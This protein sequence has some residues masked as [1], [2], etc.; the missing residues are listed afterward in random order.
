MASIES[1]DSMDSME[2]YTVHDKVYYTT[3]FTIRKKYILYG[4][5]YTVCYTV[6]NTIVYQIAHM[7]FRFYNS[8]CT[9]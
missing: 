1:M 6:W 5:W 9:I 4:V 2:Y 7:R 3:W 8:C